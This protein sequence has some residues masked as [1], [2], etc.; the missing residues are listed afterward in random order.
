MYLM[1]VHCLTGY[2]DMYNFRTFRTVYVETQTLTYKMSRI[3]M[4]RC[5]MKFTNVYYCM[6]NF[7]QRLCCNGL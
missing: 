6:A 7:L 4:S 3:G 1:R 5:R 2:Y